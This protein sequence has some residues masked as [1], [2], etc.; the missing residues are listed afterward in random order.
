MTID[1]DFRSASERLI[2]E[3]SQ[4]AT[5]GRFDRI[6]RQHRPVARMLVVVAVVLIPV[7]F[8][9]VGWLNAQP[10][11]DQRFGPAD[12]GPSS[13][14]VV[15]VTE[16]VAPFGV[17]SRIVEDEEGPIEWVWKAEFASAEKLDY[18][19]MTQQGE[20]CYGRSEPPKSTEQRHV[21]KGVAF[22]V[23]V[24]VQEVPVVLMDEPDGAQ[25]N[26][27]N[28]FGPDDWVC[29]ISH[30][31]EV[32]L[33]VGSRVWWSLDGFTWNVIEPFDRFGGVNGDGS[34]LIWSGSGPLGY[35]VLG[36]DRRDN[37]YSPDL[38]SWFR[39]AP[40]NVPDSAPT[41]PFGWIGPTGILVFDEFIAVGAD[42]GVWV[43]TPRAEE[44]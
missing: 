10:P 44:K 23:T 24:G 19:H 35:V 3:T 29:H 9:V 22:S 43:G 42:Q 4:A 13:E 33:A 17:R 39:I 11:T 26:L 12:T 36:Y 1:N 21:F 34:A 37:W 25:T 2:A 38:V 28:P 5:Q 31:D 18:G 27:G 7:L 16:F 32:L 14:P 6:T 40:A 41:M 8:A 15:S 30:N 20:R